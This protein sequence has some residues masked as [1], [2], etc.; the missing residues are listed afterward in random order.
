MTRKNSMFLKSMDY[1]AVINCNS[2]IGFFRVAGSK[3][4][5]RNAGRVGSGWCRRDP[6]RPGK[7]ADLPTRRNFSEKT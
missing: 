1:H 5:T 2:G 3:F 7:V 4:S 6:T